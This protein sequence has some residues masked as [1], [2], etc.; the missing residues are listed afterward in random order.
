[1]SQKIV[2]LNQNL[3]V[4]QEIFSFL[5]SS[6]S[7]LA[8]IILNS[9]T[10]KKICF[11]D[12]SGDNEMIETIQTCKVEDVDNLSLSL[13]NYKRTKMKVG[14]IFSKLFLKK[15]YDY[16]SISDSMIETFIDSYKSFFD[17]SNIKF[18]IVEG[19]DIKK[20]YYQDN[21]FI[22]E[23]IKTSTLWK[24]CMRY[25]ERIKFLDIY[26][27]NPNIKMVVLLTEQNGKKVVRSRALL[28]HDVEVLSGYDLEKVNVMD[29][30]YSSFSSD[31]SL[32]K[33]WADENNYLSKWEQNS[34]SHLFFDVKG[35]CK[36]IKMKFKLEKSHFDWYPYIDTFTYFDYRRGVLHNDQ[37]S[38]EWTYKLVQTD[39]GL[40]KVE[41]NEEDEETYYDDEF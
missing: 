40:E 38:P 9:E 2:R 21:Y 8:Q 25:S 27:K 17:R 5:T 30:I 32:F 18:E 36:K 4:S 28:W 23:N 12:Y 14:K 20:W 26:S 33:K 7:Y 39:G 34:K 31:V 41:Y 10:A 15:D 24:S 35:E 3:Y 29:R 22:P 19:D 13:G 11:L 37:Y 16:Y 1:M 6:S